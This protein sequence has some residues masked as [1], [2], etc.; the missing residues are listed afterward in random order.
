MIAM[1]T[2]WKLRHKPFFKVYE[3]VTVVHVGGAM[4]TCYKYKWVEVASLG[5]H[6]LFLGQTFSEVVH[7]PAD[8]HGYIERNRIYYSKNKNGRQI[9]NAE[10]HGDAVFLMILSN[11]TKLKYKKEDRRNVVDDDEKIT[12]V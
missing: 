5:D 9:L 12:S 1:I 3:L 2:W 11:D 6:A 10:V 8:M 4:T 7:V